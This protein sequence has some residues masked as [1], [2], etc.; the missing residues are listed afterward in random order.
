MRWKYPGVAGTAPM[1]APT[2][3]SAMNA[4]TLSAP[5]WRMVNSSSS[6]QERSHAGHAPFARQRYGLHGEMCSAGGRIAANGRRLAAFPPNPRA[7]IVAPWNDER[8]PITRCREPFP[9]SR[10]YWIAIFTAFSVASEPPDTNQTLP[11]PSGANSSMMI[12]AQLSMA[13]VVKACVGA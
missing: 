1:V 11:K 12:R 8:R 3:G 4:A 6:A 5:T 13:S 7:A 9:R 2:T 10:W